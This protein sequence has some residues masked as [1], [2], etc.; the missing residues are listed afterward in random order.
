MLLLESCSSLKDIDGPV[1]VEHSIKEGHCINIIS[2]KVQQV[3]EESKLNDKTWFEIRRSMILVPPETWARI[4]KYILAQCKKHKC[5][6][7]YESIINKV[8]LL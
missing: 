8:D 5:D 2:G 4:K 6:T 3:D 7:G 1:C